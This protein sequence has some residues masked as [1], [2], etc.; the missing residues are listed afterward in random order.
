MS[1]LSYNALRD[2]QIE[3]KTHFPSSI[4]S[5]TLRKSS[6]FKSIHFN[7]RSSREILTRGSGSRR[8]RLPFA[9]YGIGAHS[10]GEA[11]LKATVL[12]PV[13]MVLVDRA[14]HV[15]ST[16]ITQILADGSFE[17]SFATFARDDA[18][19]TTRRLVL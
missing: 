10:R 16:L 6:D 9:L 3:S 18:V 4:Q 2:T 17:E 1:L 11:L 8:W 14:V 19:M 7:L 12:A 15:P 13:S 5:H